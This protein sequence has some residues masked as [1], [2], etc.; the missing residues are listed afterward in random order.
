MKILL[1]DDDAFLRDMYATKFTQAGDTVHAAEDGTHAL[2]LL[3]ENK[4]D[5]VLMDMVMPS[6]TGLELLEKINEEDLRNG[7]KCIVLSNQSESTDLEAAKGLGA[8]GYIVKAELIPSE[9][10][11]K[12]HNIAK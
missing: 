8:D 2:V 6:M 9:V 3:R 11:T 12:V 1:V 4:F 5:V 10:V 7:A